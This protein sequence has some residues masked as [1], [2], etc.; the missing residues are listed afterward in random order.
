MLVKK[1]GLLSCFIFSILVFLIN[2]L[3]ILGS[4]LL[5]E[6]FLTLLFKISFK[7]IRYLIIIILPM[8]LINLLFS[9]ITLALLVVFRLL[10]MFFLVVILNHYISSIQIAYLFYDIFH[11]KD[12]FLI[13]AISISFIPIMRDEM[14]EIKKCL[15]V[16]GYKFNLKNGHLLF[17][18][19]INNMFTKVS[20]LEKI[21]ISRGY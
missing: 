15:K 18:T 8:F 19:F 16:R 20:E 1:V 3:Y 5:L 7:S 11:S 10:I 17:I 13:I 4:I 14:C 9:G 2:N 12:L 21:I 6:I